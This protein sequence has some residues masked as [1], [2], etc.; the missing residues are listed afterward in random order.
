MAEQAA[1]L[2][3]NIPG[4]I[5]KASELSLGEASTNYDKNKIPNSWAWQHKSLI[6]VLWRQIIKDLPEFNAIL[7]KELIPLPTRPT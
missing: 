5:P 1:T 2:Q 3:I 6:P 4:S 7:S